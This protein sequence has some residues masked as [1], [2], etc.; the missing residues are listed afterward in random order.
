MA[1]AYL[2][3]KDDNGTLSLVREETN[4]SIADIKNAINGS[5]GLLDIACDYIINSNGVW[6]QPVAKHVRLTVKSGDVINI[7][8]GNI[9]TVY[10]FLKSNATASQNAQADFSTATGYTSR[11]TLNADESTGNITVPPDAVLLYISVQNNSGTNQSPVSV[12]INGVQMVYNIRKEIDFL[13]GEIS[14]LSDEIDTMSERVEE[15]NGNLFAK[16]RTLDLWGMRESYDGIYAPI[17]LSSLSFLN[18]LGVELYNS[19]YKIKHNI[20]VSSLKNTSANTVTVTN[21]SELES[22]ISGA[23]S[24]DTIIVK[25]G[26]YSYITIN[27]PLNIIGEKGVIFAPPAVTF[28]STTT[29]GIYRTQSNS[30]SANPVN[31]YYIA[32]DGSPV[33]LHHAASTNDV[34][35]TPGSWFWSQSVGSVYIHLLNKKATD[36]SDIV[37]AQSTDTNIIKVKATAQNAKIYLEKISVLGGKSNVWAEDSTSYTSQK[38]IAKDCKFFCASASNALSLRGVDGFF[39]NCECAYAKLDG[40]N[41]HKNDSAN[42][43]GGDNTGTLSNGLEV[44]CVGHDNGVTDTGTSYSDNGS[45]C[46]DGGKCVR[47]NGIYYNNKGGNVADTSAN[48]VS[49]NFGCYAFDST[50]PADTNRADFWAQNGTEMHLYGCRSAGDSQYNL[51]AGTNAVIYTSKSEYSTTTGTIVPM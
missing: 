14:N 25:E 23:T 1:D 40:F 3:V 49:H 48:T 20:D 50:A 8:A 13:S 24:G 37:I 26:R 43:S 38:L 21:Q 41:Y 16:K 51:W 7:T 6:T 30:I 11:I 45:T 44:D 12:L 4:T 31:V 46:H 35:S 15:D 19:G 29:P 36:G 47:I 22:A 2:K 28:V 5:E 9:A 10:A 39:Q 42:N 33:F 27:K 17:D 34:V 18:G 32:D